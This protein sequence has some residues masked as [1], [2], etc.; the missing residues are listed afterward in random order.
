MQVKRNLLYHY[1]PELESYRSRIQ[2]DAAMAISKEHL[3]LLVNCVT[4]IYMSTSQNL[5]P[6]LAHGEITYDLL[7]LLFKP[8]TLVYT[9]C[10]STKKPR[11]VTYDSAEEKEN[12]SK[13]KYL[14]MAC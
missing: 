7:P 12:R 2:A 14:S 10:F 5:L 11:C 9:T 3:D 1:L 13:E 6:L 8:N 4:A